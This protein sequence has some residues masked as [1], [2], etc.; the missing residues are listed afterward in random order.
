MKGLVEG[1]LSLEPTSVEN[2]DGCHTF[3]SSVVNL[4][5]TTTSVSSGNDAGRGWI[6][7]DASDFSGL[8]KIMESRC[9]CAVEVRID[10]RGFEV[11][12]EGENCEAYL[13]SEWD[14]LYTAPDNSLEARLTLLIDL[15]AGPWLS[16]HPCTAQFLS[17]AHDPP[18]P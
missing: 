6:K 3:I 5:G 16:G 7:W 4:G 2:R 13:R 18:A 11:T 12:S 9:G 10:G 8:G 14:S 17:V 15:P 1:A